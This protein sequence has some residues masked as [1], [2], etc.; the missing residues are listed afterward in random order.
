MDALRIKN[1]TETSVNNEYQMLGDQIKN[2]MHEKSSMESDIS[3]SRKSLKQWGLVKLLISPDDLQ[4]HKQNREWD[5]LA[6]RFSAGMNLVMII[7]AS[8]ESEQEEQTYTP[9]LKHFIVENIFIEG[10][11]AILPCAM[12]E[13]D[14]RQILIANGADTMNRLDRIKETVCELQSVI[15]ENFRLSLTVTLGGCHSGLNSAH[16]SYLEARETEEFISILD[17][18]FICYDEIKDKTTHRYNYSLQ[19]EE[20]ISSAVQ[21]NNIPLANALIHKVID[22]NWSDDS[23]SPNIRKLLLHDIFCTL[24]KTADEKGCMDRIY[25]LPKDLSSNDP[26]TDIKAHFTKVVDSICDSAGA[27]TETSAEK[28]LCAKV[29]EYISMNYDEP[30]LNISQTAFYF[31]L[32]PTTLSSI[33]KNETGKSLLMAINE[34]RIEKA[35]EYLQQGYS[36]ADTA[37]KVGIPE[38]SSFIRLFKKHMGITPGQVK[39]QFPEKK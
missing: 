22:A 5:D 15:Y 27:A 7:R 13:L 1:D 8:A 33:F 25:M 10:I 18:D 28:E 17:Q 2:L 30:S 36:V 39:N 14:G 34:F 9:E 21:N 38:S 12:A 16:K 23:I 32:S 29:L 11:S 26:V 6:K 35:M 20:R 19:A 31:H 37:A 3:K 4:N 24:L